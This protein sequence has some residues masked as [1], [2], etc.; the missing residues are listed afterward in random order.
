VK[1]ST[2]A[3]YGMM[4]VAAIMWATSG[5]FTEL[6]IEGGASA[7]QVSVFA[8]VVTAVI[9][10]PLIYFLDRKSIRIEMKDFWPFLVFSLVTGTFFTL[11]WYI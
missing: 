2:N 1:I 7:V 9:L 6:A 3:A 10:L 11:A 8:T 5:T 4:I